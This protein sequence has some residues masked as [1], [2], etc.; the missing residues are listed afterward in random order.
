MEL[1]GQSP[2]KRTL[3]G[4]TRRIRLR[5][6]AVPDPVQHS[7]CLTAITFIAYRG[8]LSRLSIDRSLL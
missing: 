3:E 1:V 2:R 6:L 4:F 8:E 5:L 7:T